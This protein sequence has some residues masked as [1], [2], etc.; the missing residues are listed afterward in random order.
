M[1]KF[2]EIDVTNFKKVRLIKI[3]SVITNDANGWVNKI[4][5]LEMIVD[6]NNRI[7]LRGWATKNIWNNF[8]RK[9]VNSEDLDYIFEQQLW[10]QRNIRWVCFFLFNNTQKK[11]Q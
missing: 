7:I 11:Q 5:N 10:T 3:Y 2:Y 6:D 4:D 8:L 1:K 9:L